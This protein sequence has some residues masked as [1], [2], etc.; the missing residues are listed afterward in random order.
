[1]TNR[2]KRLDAGGSE[3]RLSGVWRSAPA[4]FLPETSPSN[5]VASRQT[6]TLSFLGFNSLIFTPS[7]ESYLPG[8]N[9]YSARL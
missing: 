4:L 7:R 8:S 2:Y 1:M 9:N 6:A 5:N 3:L